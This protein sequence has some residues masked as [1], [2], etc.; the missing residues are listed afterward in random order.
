MRTIIDVMTGP[1]GP[2]FAGTTWD[3][4]RAF[5]KAIFA[6]PMSDVD[7]DVVRRCTGRQAL[8][9]VPAREAWMI[10]GRRGG[11]SRVAALLAVFLAC[12]RRYTLAA[13]ERGVVQV[14]AA[15]RR[16]ARVI[17]RY[18]RALLHASPMVEGLIAAERKESIDLA[19]GITI[20]IHT[21]SFKAVRGYTVVA[22]VLDEIAFWPTDDAAANPDTE[23]LAAL[24]P[25][26]ATI[27][28]ALLI[29]LSS[30]YARRGELWRAYQKHFG[31]D[32]ASV[33]VWQADT[34]TMNPS[35][36][37][38]VIDDAYSADEVAASAEYGAQFRRDVEMLFVREALDA[39]TIP[40]RLQIPPQR[41]ARY[42]AF[43]D[44]SGGSADAMTLAIAHVDHTGIGVLDALAERRPPFSPDA[45]T[46]EFAGLLREYQITTLE[47]DRYAGEWPR[48]RFRA[49]GITY[50]PCEQPRTSLYSALLPLVNSGRVELL[51]HPKLL[52]QLTMLERRTSRG[53][54]ELI[55]H[56][57][58]GHDD[59]A[60]AA[61]GALAMFSLTR[62]STITRRKI[63]GF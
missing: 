43:V 36:D 13:G 4:W 47:G 7:G 27:P 22:A 37:Q 34:R 60:N 31:Q 42:R 17:L 52:R 20:E 24:R 46:Q 59:L 33:L 39:V 21:A 55:D 9:T 19:N 48:E 61:A 30:P 12:F 63:T 53:G 58:G 5:L 54:R 25:A 23:I 3:A 41:G 1:F 15:D 16:Q 10:V 32:P 50:V 18:V 44:P 38:A 56:P 28:D 49:H 26:M 6:L 57:P 62:A 45:V 2:F 51:D 40:H 14:I 11:K 29:A 8:P 35:V